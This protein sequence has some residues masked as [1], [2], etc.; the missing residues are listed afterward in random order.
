MKKFNKLFAVILAFLLLFGCIPYAAAADKKLT[1]NEDGSFRILQIS[2]IQQSSSK[3]HERTFSTIKLSIAKYKPN[4]IV[5][6]GDNIS[7]ANTT[8]Y[9]DNAVKK[10][11]AF[12]LIRAEIKFLLP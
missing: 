9:F 7:G 6:T 10:S 5:M 1:V 11:Q 3:I 2:D 4:L 8:E 12:L